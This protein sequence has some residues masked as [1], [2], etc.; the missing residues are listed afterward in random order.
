MYFYRTHH[1]MHHKKLFRT[2]HLVHH[3]SVNPSP[4][5]SYAYHPLEVVVEAG[6]FA[7]FQFTIP[8][9]P[10]HLF[11]FF[12]FMIVYNV[13]G[14]L[15]YERYPAGFNKHWLGK[16]ITT[17]VKH[18][19]HDQYFKGNYGLYFTTWARLLGTLRND[20]DQRFEEVTRKQK[21]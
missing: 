10:L 21:R 15:G 2:M 1:A 3:K 13:Y 16:W 8:V 20:C 6:I 5:V 7:V 12:F 4:C 17:S 11:L 9:H 19:Q 18:N 14:H